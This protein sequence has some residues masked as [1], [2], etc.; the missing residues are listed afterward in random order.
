MNVITKMKTRYMLVK[1]TDRQLI[2]DDLLIKVRIR[3]INLKATTPR[4]FLK[5]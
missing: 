1:E 3:A 4:Y 2:L 5:R